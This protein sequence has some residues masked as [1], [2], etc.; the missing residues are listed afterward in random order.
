MDITITPH[1]FCEKNAVVKIPASKSHTIRRLLL[2]TLCEGV[3]QIDFPLDSLDAASCLSTCRAFGADIKENIKK[4][5]NGIDYIES[6]IVRGIGDAK[7]IGKHLY[8]AGAA[9]LDVGNSGTTL[10]LG[11]AAASHSVAPIT[12]YG[13]DQIAKRSA[14]P[15]LQSLQAFGVKVQSAA[16]GCIP[17]T[18]EGP[19]RGGRTS[20]ECPTSQYLSALLIAAPLA[21]SDCVCEIDVPLL[22]EK[23][24]IEM[25]LSYLRR[26]NIDIKMNDDF[27][28]FAITGGAKYSAINGSVTADFSSAAFPALAAVI[29]GATVELTG[30]DK[31]D[32]QG[33]KV[34]FDILKTVGANVQWEKEKVIVSSGSKLHGGV[35]DL[36][37]TPDLLPACAV[38]G[39][40]CM[41]ETRLLNVA[42]ARIKETDRI[43]VMCNELK[44]LGLDIA[45]LDDGLVI[46]GGSRIKG[47]IVNGH[48]DHRVVMALACCAL[49]AQGDVT[50]STAEAASVTYPQFL[51]LCR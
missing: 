9:Q 16:N 30:L 5:E 29:T 36:N 12:F 4:D 6:W 32:F 26:Q 15:L 51:Q 47:G 38:L 28:Y 42:H 27:S 22:N 35:F 23:P 37:D 24:Y 34:F 48:G 21:S 25:T 43:A 7:N 45:E 31:N 39:A 46:N 20:I 2:A 49:G 18:V 33:D 50:I 17:I 10:F 40:Y 14:L 3:S 13:D 11:L 19:W 44:K 8:D 41:G 1:I